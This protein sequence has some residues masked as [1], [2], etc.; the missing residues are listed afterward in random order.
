MFRVVPEMEIA[1]SLDQG[2]SPL[3][4][5][6]LQTAELCLC[7]SKGGPE[8]RGVVGVHRGSLVPRDDLGRSLVHGYP[9]F[10]AFPYLATY[11]GSQIT[12]EDTR[13]PGAHPKEASGAD[14]GAVWIGP[15]R[16]LNF[17]EPFRAHSRRTRSAPS[18]RFRR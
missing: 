3:A 7:G 17:V 5:L 4:H 15:A 9:I 8:G 16:R 2:Y 11:I 1:T 13:A 6:R 12:A 18:T 10:D 14:V